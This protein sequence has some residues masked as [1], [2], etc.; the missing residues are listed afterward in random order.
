METKFYKAKD[1]LSIGQCFVLFSIE[2]TKTDF[3]GEKF[4]L[5]EGF[6]GNHSTFSERRTYPKIS[7]GTFNEFILTQ[8]EVCKDDLFYKIM[9]PTYQERL[10]KSN[11]QV[12]IE[13]REIDS[14][15][16]SLLGDKFAGTL[17]TIQMT[18]INTHLRGLIEMY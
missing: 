1:T 9:M 3:Y 2:E 11:N 10:E 13:W 17:A 5:F 12:T 6:D 14:S 18:T 4:L 16:I 15:I 7:N 8:M